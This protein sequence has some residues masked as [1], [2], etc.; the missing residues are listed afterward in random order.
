M[1]EQRELKLNLKMNLYS[2]EKKWGRYFLMEKRG[3]FSIDMRLE[4]RPCLG[5]TLALA[6][7]GKQGI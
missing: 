5:E 1:I 6:V 7:E 3:E 2:H 4:G